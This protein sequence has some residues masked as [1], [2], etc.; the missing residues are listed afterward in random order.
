MS[1]IGEGRILGVVR[2]QIF[3]SSKLSTGWADEASFFIIRLVW[4]RAIYWLKM[5]QIG[6]GRILGVV[7]AQIFDS[8]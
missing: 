6:E 2:A 4:A 1:Q 3:D 5:S 8:S 7:H